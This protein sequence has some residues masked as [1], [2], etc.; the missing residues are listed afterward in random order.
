MSGRSPGF[1]KTSFPLPGFSPG[2]GQP[3]PARLKESRSPSGEEPHYPFFWVRRCA[4]HFP[5]G[6]SLSWTSLRA[7][8]SFATIRPRRN[9]HDAR[10]PGLRPDQRIAFG[11]DLVPAAL[12]GP[13]EFRERNTLGERG[14]LC[15][16]AFG[17][18][19]DPEGSVLPVAAFTQRELVLGK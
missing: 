1:R 9:D 4:I 11:W 13:R 15:P 18:E 3:P 10:F 16:R 2:P 7:V 17:P 19:S 5:G 8:T 12:G 6:R 14:P